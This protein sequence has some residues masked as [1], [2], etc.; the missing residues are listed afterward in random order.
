M[1]YIRVNSNRNLAWR[2]KKTPLK[3]GA[4]LKKP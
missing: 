4:V 3:R 1:G 2:K